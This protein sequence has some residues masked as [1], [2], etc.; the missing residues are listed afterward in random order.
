MPR[1][2]ALIGATTSASYPTTS[3]TRHEFR[4]IC[5][6]RVLLIM[7]VYLHLVFSTTKTMFDA[8]EC[9]TLLKECGTYH[10]ATGTGIVLLLTRTNN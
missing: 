8:K 5:E 9:G 10:I 7:P 2:A 1:R 6:Q 4:E 3:S